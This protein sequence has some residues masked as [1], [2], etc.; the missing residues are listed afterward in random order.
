MTHNERLALGMVPRH[1]GDSLAEARYLKN[2]DDY[3]TSM[4]TMTPHQNPLPHPR[5][6]TLGI[7]P[8]SA[9]DK[10]GEEVAREC[11]EKLHEY[12]EW[13]RNDPLRV[14]DSDKT[15][16]IIL[17]ALPFIAFLGALLVLLVSITSYFW[18]QVEWFLLCWLPRR[19]TARESTF[20]GRPRQAL[21]RQR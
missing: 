13:V 16:S 9:P 11:A 5:L 4:S 8:P 21:R 19:R 6:T 7:P 2:R 18:P 1:E 14:P 17:T 20:L 10:S 12:F 3:R 15:E